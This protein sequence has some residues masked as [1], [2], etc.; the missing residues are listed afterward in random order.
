M[1]PKKDNNEQQT[2]LDVADL[3]VVFNS[4][5]SHFTA[6]NNVSFKVNKG[7]FFGIIGESGSGKSTIGKTLVRL[8]K[9]SGGSINLDGRLIG[10]KKISRSDKSWLHQNAQMIFQDPMS[11]LNPIK[12]VLKLVSEPIMINK[13]IHK[14][15]KELY[16]KLTYIRPYFHYSFKNKEFSLTYEY[17]SNYFKKLAQNYHD[18]FKALSELKLSNNDFNT[19]YKEIV[20]LMDDISEKVQSNIELSKKYLTDYKNILDNFI[21]DYDNKQYEQVDLEFDQAKQEQAQ[22]EKVLKYSQKVLDLKKQKE[23][24]KQE[25]KDLINNF[26]EVYL[27]RNFSELLSWLTTVESEVKNFKH[28]MRFTNDPLDYVYAG[29]N[30]FWKKS[31]LR[32]I[33]SIKNDRYFEKE[34][35]DLLIEKIN[36]YFRNI[37]EPL[38]NIVI[39][40]SIELKK[41]I[42]KT[43]IF[44]KQADCYFDLAKQLHKVIN[45]KLDLSRLEEF[46]VY[47]DVV[48]SNNKFIVENKYINNSF[49]EWKTTISN[50]FKAIITEINNHKDE[51]QKIANEKNVDVY[52][53]KKEINQLD[54]EIKKSYS[55]YQKNNKENEVNEVELAIRNTFDKKTKRDVIIE[56]YKNKLPE[57]LSKR[58]YLSEEVKKLREDYRKTKFRFSKLVNEKI[59]DLANQNKWKAKDVSLLMGAIKLRLKSMDTVDFEYKI[60][61]KDKNIYRNLFLKLP[62][63]LNWIYL[64]PLRSILIRDKVFDALSQVGLKP[65]HAYRYPHEFSGGQ[66]Q[67]IVIARALITDPKIVIADEPISALDVSI[68]AQIVNIMK[69]MVEKHGVTFLFIAHDL[70]MVNYACNNVIIMHRGRILERGSVDKI[71]KNPIHPYTKSLMK[72]SPKLSNIHLD[73]ASFD[74]GFNYN[75]DYSVINKPSYF[76][77]SD[78]HEVF[79]TKEQFDLWVNQNR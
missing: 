27:F 50:N 77:V 6:V 2:L 70:S 43:N 34:Q 39:N 26:N 38:V 73:L 76:K 7:D 64:F 60:V 31:E 29:I 33:N 69:E 66:R 56:N 17:E 65:E 67:R 45:K 55:A 71:F 35:L 30:Y 13:M 24:K 37:F 51:S 52:H 21:K 48:A 62:K 15:A 68:Q 72:A 10:N 61:H 74:E 9:A 41:D 59:H 57:V 25:L 28:K 20:F 40:Y 22:K 16:K 19:G 11:S 12:T 4:R 78:N 5:G 32:I 75:K 44:Y 46:N 63:W 8:N 54:Q 79:C 42:L 3:S 58:E 47:L 14:K 18:G 1:N 49:D 36:E 53:L 23:N